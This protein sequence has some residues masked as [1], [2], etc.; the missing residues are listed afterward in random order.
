MTND[1][2]LLITFYVEGINSIV[3]HIC[4]T[5]NAFFITLWEMYVN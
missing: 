5:C 3:L 2:N 1:I 4:A